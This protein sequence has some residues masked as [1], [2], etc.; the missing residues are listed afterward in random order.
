M[1]EKYTPESEASRKVLKKVVIGATIFGAGVLAGKEMGGN[2]SEKKQ[3]DLDANKK[4]EV[5]VDDTSE[6]ALE[7]S[8]VGAF[9]VAQAEESEQEKKHNISLEYINSIKEKIGGDSLNLGEGRTQKE[10]DIITE[11]QKKLKSSSDLATLEGIQTYIQD[12]DLILSSIKG[13]P[14]RTFDYYMVHEIQEGLKRGTDFKT[15][16]G[17]QEYV[18]KRN[19][20]L[21]GITGIEQSQLD[22]YIINAAQEALKR[23]TDFTNEEGL[24]RYIEKRDFLLKNSNLEQSKLDYYMLPELQKAIKEYSGNSRNLFVKFVLDNFPSTKERIGNI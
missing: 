10:F 3:T 15:L 20:I 9:D 11:L 24:K 13:I 19:I 6:K 14:Q 7:D 18:Y 8:I 12:R 5:V 17:L 4:I 21:K 1:K 22:G 23:S 2:N 16:N